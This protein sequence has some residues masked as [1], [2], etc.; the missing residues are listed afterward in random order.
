[1]PKTMSRHLTGRKCP[2]NLTEP[3]YPSISP[4]YLIIHSNLLTNLNLMKQEINWFFE[5]ENKKIIPTKEFDNY[6][7][8]FA[9]RIRE[10]LFISK[11]SMS[12]EEYQ[13]FKA[14]VKMTFGTGYTTKLRKLLGKTPKTFLN[15]D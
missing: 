7:Q 8:N 1:M 3:E 11:Q 4:E 14:L 5:R 10:L 15:F 13:R 6:W 2:T 9:E 12:L